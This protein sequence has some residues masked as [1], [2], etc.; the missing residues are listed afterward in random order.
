MKNAAPKQ[1]ASTA[2]NEE[3]SGKFKNNK[4][5]DQLINIIKHYKTLIKNQL[6]IRFIVNYNEMLVIK[7]KF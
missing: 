3:A 2:P 4:I 6:I 5:Y 7:I 1:S